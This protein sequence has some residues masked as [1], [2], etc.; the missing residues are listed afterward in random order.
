[1]GILVLTGAIVGGAQG[2]KL[3]TAGL[4]IGIFMGALAGWLAAWWV[5]RSFLEY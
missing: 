1:M 5:R 4:I 2:K 3:G